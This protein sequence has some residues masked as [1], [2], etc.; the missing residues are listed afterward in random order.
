MPSRRGRATRDNPAT[1]FGDLQRIED[2]AALDADELRQVETEVIF[3]HSRSVLSRNDSPDIGFTFSVNPY[4]GC[5]HGCIYCYARP[6]H[7]Y[8]GYSAGLD[9]ERKILVKTGAPDLLAKEFDRRSWVPQTIAL[10]G[11]TDPYQP[12]ERRFR[13]SRGILQVCHRFGNPVSVITKNHLVT[14]DLD[15]L[16]RMA[17][18]NLVH[19]TLSVTTLDDSLTA[20][21]EPRTSRPVSRIEA[22]RE[23]ASA[24]VSVGVNVAPIIPGIT[25]EEIPRILQAAA[26]AGASTAG[27]QILRLPGAVKGLFLD[28]LA[29][30]Y[31]DRVDR[32]VNRLRDLRGPDLNDS[33]FYHRMRGSGPW[34][35]AIRSLFSVSVKRLGLNRSLPVLENHRF[36]RRHSGQQDLFDD[37]S[38]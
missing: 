3:D 14:R 13:L 16:A 29:L 38:L 23:L 21:M 25:D 30:R 4:R 8:L 24:G 34:A 5:E 9:F 22:I 31:P 35:D 6:S 36:R 20:D 7:E 17:A 2:P 28:W 1:R 10:C 37:S 19:V 27:Y 32:V 18:R 11:N 15:V 26:A 33:R 12:L